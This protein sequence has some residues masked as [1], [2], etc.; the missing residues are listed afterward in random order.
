MI[1]Y[2]IQN[3]S[4]KS[5]PYAWWE[6]C[7]TDNELDLLQKYASD[8]EQNALIA[9]PGDSPIS[10]EKH[11]RSNISWLDCTEDNKWVYSKLSH[12]IGKLN[13]Q[14]Y[15]YD[16]DGFGEKIQM[17]NY[18]ESRQ[19]TYDW[20]IDSGTGLTRK[21]SLVVQLSR[22]E[23]YEGG[24]LEIMTGSKPTQM[25]KSRGSITVF[26]SSTLHRVTPVI[27]GSRQSLVA[28]ITGPDFR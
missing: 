13:A 7:F 14:F 27:K 3:Y 17:T 2:P 22:P 28:W 15:N 9:G 24:N 1:K 18:E 19:G 8:A 26:P 23:E 20:H 11:R 10:A 5:P 12:V 6:N 21:I 16:L 4:I 25:E